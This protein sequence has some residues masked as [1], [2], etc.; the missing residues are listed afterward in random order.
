MIL[1]VYH[2]ASIS[3]MFKQPYELMRPAGFD[4]RALYLHAT[5][6]RSTISCMRNIVRPAGLDLRA[7]LRTDLLAT[8]ALI[9]APIPPVL[10]LHATVPTREHTCLYE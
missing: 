7:E 10:Q 8:S 9:L 1:L 4:L 5:M 2:C 6:S 3:F